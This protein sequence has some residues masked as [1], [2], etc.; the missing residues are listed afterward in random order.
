MKN[1]LKTNTI[2]Q[3]NQTSAD[4]DSAEQSKTPTIQVQTGIR[5]GWVPGQN[6]R[7]AIQDFRASLPSDLWSPE[8]R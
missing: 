4:R 6:V 3:G 2:S 7:N 1:N 8:I 5:A